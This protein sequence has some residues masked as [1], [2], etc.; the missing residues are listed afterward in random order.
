M[1]KLKSNVP[2]TAFVCFG[3]VATLFTSSTAHTQDANIIEITQAACQFIEVENG[4]DH[5]F[6]SNHARECQ[7]INKTTGAIRLKAAKVL[8]L[9]PGTYT[10]R[11]TNQDVPYDLGFW[12]RE[13]GYQLGNPFHKETKISV[14]GG[15]LKQG[16]TK[17]YVVTLKPGEY[18][19]SC[20]LN[21]TPSYKLLVAP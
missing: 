9:K 12:I 17:D 8:K 10:F 3:L 4:V 5:N 19:Y 11:V 15:G 6:K 16:V 1:K 18:R 20:P 2:A 13:K 7:A 14:A 21:P